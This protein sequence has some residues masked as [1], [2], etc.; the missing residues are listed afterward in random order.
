VRCRGDPFYVRPHAAADI[1]QKQHVHRHVF[2][3][4]VADFLWLAILEENEI[5]YVQTGY[6]SVVTIEHLGI[7]ANQ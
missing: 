5:F 6:G 2:V 3:G 1:Q 4:K 7:H